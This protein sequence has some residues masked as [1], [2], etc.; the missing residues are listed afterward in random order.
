MNKGQQFWVELWR[1]GRTHFHREE[2]NPDLIAYWPSLHNAL[3][4]TILVPLCGKS[5]DML[6]LAQQ[7]FNV[8]GIELS[9]DAVKQFAA[10]HQL[11]LQHETLGHISH[12]FTP[13]ISLWV[14]DIFALAPSLIAPVD[15]IY[16]RAALIALPEKLRAGYVDSCLQWLKPRGAILLKTLSYN[17]HE[18]EGPPFSVS[19]EE[20]IQLY[21]DQCSEIQCIKSSER[22]KNLDDHLFQRGVSKIKDSVWSIR[23]K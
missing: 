11:D 6:W 3:N 23:K 20:V 16:D 17:Q 14:A 1:E 15:A 8:I 2:V 19:D 9:E 4:A 22:E 13:S 12:Y 7:G 21:R 10:Q 5:L 18:M